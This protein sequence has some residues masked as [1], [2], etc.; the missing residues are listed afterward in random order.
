MALGLGIFAVWPLIFGTVTLNW[1][2]AKTEFFR[3][4]IGASS[5]NESAE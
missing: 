1:M 2:D 4:E 3:D 5:N